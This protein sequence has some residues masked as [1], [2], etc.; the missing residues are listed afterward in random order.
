ME[1]F[2]LELKNFQLRSELR[3]FGLNPA[4]WSIIKLQSLSYLIKNK[5]DESFSLYGQLE[6][7]KSK[8]TWKSL[9]LASF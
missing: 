3:H 6:Y 1:T 2:N 4:D 7:K 5:V 8:P 9:E